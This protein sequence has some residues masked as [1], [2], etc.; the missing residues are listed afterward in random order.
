MKLCA[1]GALLSILSGCAAPLQSARVGMEAAHDLIAIE[2]PP[3]TALDNER[4][5]T[6]KVTYNGG[7]AVFNTAVI[8]D[9]IGENIDGY[10]AQ[11]KAILRSITEMK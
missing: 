5:Q 11:I 2:C 6:M 4:C 10:V 9:S 1:A 7:V 8:A 3:G